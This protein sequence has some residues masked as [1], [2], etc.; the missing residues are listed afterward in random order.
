MGT[1]LKFSIAYHPQIDGQ[2]EKKIQTI[3]DML[4]VCIMD[5]TRN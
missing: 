4:S 5:F 1:Q 2:S 3:K